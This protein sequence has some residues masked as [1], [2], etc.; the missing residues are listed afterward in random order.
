M[1]L[2]ALGSPNLLHRTKLSW[3]YARGDI[4]PVHVYVDVRSSVTSLRSVLYGAVSSW[5]DL[6]HPTVHLFS[7]KDQVSLAMEDAVES[8]SQAFVVIANP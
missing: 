3:A 6:V 2:G 4:W 8:V 1:V 5:R 7:T